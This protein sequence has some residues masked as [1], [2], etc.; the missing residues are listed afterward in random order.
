VTTIFNS[1]GVVSMGLLLI[2]PGDVAWLAFANHPAVSG[3][4]L[5]RAELL[6]AQCRGGRMGRARGP[7]DAL[8]PYVISPRNTAVLS[9]RPDLSWNPIAGVSQYTVSLMNGDTTIWTKEVNTNRIT[10]PTDANTLQPG[11]D[12]T[13]VITAG[14]G[15]ASTEEDTQ[16]AF[17]LLS[18]TKAATVRQ[19]ET[20][21]AAQ[22]A[23]EETALLKA[24][25][26]TGAELYSEAINTLEALVNQGTSSATVYR[27]LGDLYAR[28]D[29]NIRAEPYYLDAIPL[30]AEN[31]EEQARTQAALGELYVAIEQNQEAA[32]YFTQAKENYEKLNNQLKVKEMQEQLANLTAQG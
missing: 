11:I 30:A 14:N 27:Q 9:D 24:D 26:Y 2:L 1:I 29:L 5:D 31:L 4:E 19:A 10:Y 25:F 15:R 20:L 32:K 13:L 23:T 3:F 28:S 21:L 18:P 7:E 8:I 17:H 22:S 12:Y 16:P 6:V